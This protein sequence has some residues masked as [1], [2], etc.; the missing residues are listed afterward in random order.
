MIF[1]R[2]APADAAL[3]ASSINSGSPSFEA[4]ENSGLST[5]QVI[6]MQHAPPRCST[7]TKCKW[8]RHQF[9]K[10]PFDPQSGHFEKTSTGFFTGSFF[11]ITAVT[12]CSPFVSFKN[13]NLEIT[14]PN[15]SRYVPAWKGGA[16]VEIIGIYLW[17]DLFFW[18]E[19]G[20]S[21][22]HGPETQGTTCT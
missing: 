18:S 17:G 21:A 2:P 15:Y 8:H 7:S 11:F 4:S 13:Q 3:P 14:P 5:G 6:Q 9:L 10:R 22:V 12:L 20:P 16:D 19:I 1:P